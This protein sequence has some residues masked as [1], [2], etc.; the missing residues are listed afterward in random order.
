MDTTC[1]KAFLTVDVALFGDRGDELYVLLIL[2]GWDPFAGCW[3]LPGGHVD[4]GEDITVAA[5]REL[6]EE[7]GLDVAWLRS[8]GAYADPGRDPRGRY[9]TFVY[10]A[11]VAGTPEPAAGDDAAEARWVLVDDV[12]SGRV[13]VAFDH[14]HL[15]REA[16]RVAM[17]SASLARPL[18]AERIQHRETTPGQNESHPV[19]APT[20]EV[21]DSRT[22]GSELI[23]LVSF[24]FLHLD[25]GAVPTADRVE[26]VR[27]RLRDPARVAGLLDLDGRDRRIQEV[28]LNT[29]GA[30]ELLVNLAAY[31]CLPTASPRRIAIGCAGGK[32]RAAA[33]AELLAAGLR[34]G[35][36]EVTVTHLHAHL[37]RVLKQAS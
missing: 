28:V 35:G 3:A 27:D 19:G 33:L 30:R 31:A 17:N 4:V 18:T 26:D 23:E 6:G 24:G 8:C 5:H 16:S 21:P 7:T 36:R 1:E 20:A 11:R 12:L 13:K 29:P 37:P 9:T 25:D 34:S 22:P 10:T 15:I 32:H 14:L 2:R